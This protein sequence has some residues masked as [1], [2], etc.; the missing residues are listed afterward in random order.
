MVRR[1]S[2][3]LLYLLVSLLVFAVW[4]RCA[5][6]EALSVPHEPGMKGHPS[7]AN[8]GLLID[9]KTAPPFV[10]RRLLPDAAFL[11]AH[12]IPA[13]AWDQFTAWVQS[14]AGAARTVKWAFD[15]L[16]WPPQRY[17]E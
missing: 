8:L 6:T 1:C 13:T 7:F 5:K 9:G 12:L 10:W 16:E 4:S 15:T 17:P 11:L 3:A 2:V 14:D